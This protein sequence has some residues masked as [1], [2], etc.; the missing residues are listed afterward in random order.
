MKEPVT[1]TKERQVVGYTTHHGRMIKSSL[2]YNMSQYEYDTLYSTR[3]TWTEW[4]SQSLLP[5]FWY[6]KDRTRVTGPKDGRNRILVQFPPVT[7]KDP[8]KNTSRE[9]WR[10]S[11]PFTDSTHILSLVCRSVSSIKKEKACLTKWKTNSVC[12]IYTNNINRTGTKCWRTTHTHSIDIT[13]EISIQR[14]SSSRHQIWI[15]YPKVGL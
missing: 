1:V 9:S 6:Q 15:I 14:P 13:E 4:T 5:Y 10:D 12:N 7:Q 8:E 3:V 11:S 2:C